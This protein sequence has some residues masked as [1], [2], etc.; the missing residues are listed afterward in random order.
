[1]VLEVAEDGTIRTI[2]KDELIDFA[3]KIGGDMTT[4]CRA[5]N[6]EWEKV[7]KPLNARFP[8]IK[9]WSVRAAH[10]PELALRVESSVNGGIGDRYVDTLV[11]SRNPNLAI[12]LFSTREIALQAEVKFFHQL[13]PPKG[14]RGT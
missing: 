2:Y 10:D 4:V 12:M 6:V 11:C 13:L 3:E 5:S 9:G 8:D 7:E 1:M 14:E